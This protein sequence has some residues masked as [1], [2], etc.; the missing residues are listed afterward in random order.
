MD[1]VHL[2]P[3]EK[4]TSKSDSI[5]KNIPDEVRLQ[6][7]QKMEEKTYRKGQ[8]IFLEGSY[9]AGVFFVKDG[10]VKKYKTDQTGKE[11]IL[12]LCSTGELLGYSALL[13][14]EPYPDSAAALEVSKLQFIS[15]E[16]FMQ[17]TRSS[18]KLMLNLL[19]SLSHE[20]GVM[21]NSITVMSRMTA[22]ERLA[23]ILLL[24]SAKF[25]QKTMADVVEIILSRD[26][27]A[28]MLGVATE[29]V[30]RLLQGLKSDKIINMDGKKIIITKPLELI[31]ISKFY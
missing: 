22:K 20:F 16:A 23:L 8:R 7:E 26:D 24:L 12:Y 29:T 15:E 2:F 28:N 1:P 14:N 21:T 4:F 18:N 10:L 13:C 5:F 17:I 9:P 11:H 19:A 30:V 31:K 27:L 3:I 25:K 6:L